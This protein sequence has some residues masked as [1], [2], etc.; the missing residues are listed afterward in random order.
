MAHLRF[1][2]LY[3][4]YEVEKNLVHYITREVVERELNES[5]L[6]PSEYMKKCSWRRI[7][8]E[9]L[10]DFTHGKD[11]IEVPIG[12]DTHNQEETDA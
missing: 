10:E 6:E 8:K 4:Y 12:R 2:F 1:H 9:Y 7:V 3:H 5:L 11:V